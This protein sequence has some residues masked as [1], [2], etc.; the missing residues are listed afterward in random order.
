MTNKSATFETLN[1]LSSFSHWHAGKFSSKCTA[2]KVDVIGPENI[3]FA[4]AIMHLSAWKF[5]RDWGSEGV[6]TFFWY[7][8]TTC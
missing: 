1:C 2:L 7:M 4:G 6:K 5:Y 8:C 3:V